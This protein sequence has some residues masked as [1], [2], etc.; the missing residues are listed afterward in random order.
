M[1]DQKAAIKN[2]DMLEEMQ[3]NSVEC[4]TQ[5]LEKYNNEKNIVAHI[6]KECVRDQPGQ[7]GKTSSLLKIQRN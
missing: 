5:A 6:K 2:A 4:A 3:Q 1:C 7:H